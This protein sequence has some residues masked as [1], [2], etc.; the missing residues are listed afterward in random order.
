MLSNEELAELA[1]LLDSGSTSEAYVYNISDATR[2]NLSPIKIRC[3]EVAKLGL[4][5]IESQILAGLKKIVASSAVYGAS[6]L[7]PY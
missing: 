3:G 4:S 1:P 6:I 5:D 2:T 7:L